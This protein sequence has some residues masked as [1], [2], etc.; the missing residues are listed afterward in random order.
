M[1]S[2]P[3]IVLEVQ[4]D[5]AAW[6]ACPSGI[7]PQPGQYLAA[8]TP[9]DSLHPLPYLL[10]PGGLT[11]LAEQEQKPLDRP[12]RTLRFAT[13]LPAW[14]AGTILQLRGPLGQGF[15]MPK[16]VRR[17]LLVALGTHTER[18]LPLM[19]P[20]LEGGGGVALFTDASL[21]QLPLSVEAYPLESLPEFRGWPDYIALDLPVE[22]LSGLRKHFGLGAHAVLGIPAQ[23]LV[24]LPMP[25][26][27]IGDCG[28]CTVEGRFSNYLACKDGP[29]FDLGRLAW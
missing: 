12:G 6:V 10:F 1:Q 27:A 28:A 24:T 14:E 17:L 16:D 5:G 9:A 22:K 8:W 7:F 23:A 26:T 15:H 18:L 4:L 3:G 25:C 2:G 13:P 21:P 11:W 20:V 19:Q 29:V